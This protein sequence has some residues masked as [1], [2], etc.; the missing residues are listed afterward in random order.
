MS[1]IQNSIK[2]VDALTPLLF[3]F[4]LDYAITKVQETQEGLK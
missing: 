2:Q 4:A 1:P 3:V